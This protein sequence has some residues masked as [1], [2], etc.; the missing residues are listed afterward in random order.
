MLDL[1]R[2]TVTHIAETLAGETIAAG[3]YRAGL[4]LWIVLVAA[5]LVP[6]PKR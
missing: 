3:L 2:G 6:D 4:V 1:A 5:I